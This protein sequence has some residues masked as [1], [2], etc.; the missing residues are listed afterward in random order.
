M[1]SG[2]VLVSAS[3]GT[4]VAQ[5][6]AQFVYL[7]A[8]AIQNVDIEQTITGF[9]TGIDYE[10]SYWICGY[11]PQG[12]Q[13]TCAIEIA[14]FNHKADTFD[15]TVPA[16]TTDIGTAA[17]PWVNRTFTFP[18]EGESTKLQ[19][20]NYRSVA[21]TDAYAAFDNF[22]DSR[23]SKRPAHPH[24][25]E[26]APKKDH[27]FP[28]APASRRHGLGDSAACRR[29]DHLARAGQHGCRNDILERC[30]PSAP[31][32]ESHRAG[33]IDLANSRSADV[34]RIVRRVVD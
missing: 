11:N 28:F 22:Y 6:G 27:G 12:A 10:I 2:N 9:V 15:L 19:I 17:N 13:K 29:S 26:S 32:R 18:A 3:T 30:D 31:R 21:V 20:N 8:T 1:T 23:C 25:D 34:I 33:A 16:S 7:P 14:T 4:R 5:S 24:G